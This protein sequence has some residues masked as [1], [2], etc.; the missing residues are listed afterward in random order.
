MRPILAA[1]L[2]AFPTLLLAQDRAP[3]NRGAGDRPADISRRDL[4]RQDPVWVLLDKRK[5]LK[6]DDTQRATIEAMREDSLAASAR[7]LIDRVDSLQKANRPR[8]TA[9]MEGSGAGFGGRGR[10]SSAARGGGSPQ[11]EPTPEELRRMREG[12]AMLSTTMADLDALY[13][14][15]LAGAVQALS[16]EQADRARALVLKARER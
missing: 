3:G 9:P 4:E 2:L 8:T 5:D 16:P 7:T 14:Q 10:T 1:A 13:T 12:R 15:R 6:L 11:R